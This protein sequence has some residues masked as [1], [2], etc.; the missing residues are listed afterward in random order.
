MKEKTWEGTRQLQPQHSKPSTTPTLCSD[1]GNDRN[2]AQDGSGGTEDD[3][4]SVTSVVDGGSRTVRAKGDEVGCG[5][6]H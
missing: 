2:S 3:S 1:G 6:G 4:H 5:A